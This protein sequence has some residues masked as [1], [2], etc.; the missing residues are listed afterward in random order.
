MKLERGTR[1]RNTES[2]RGDGRRAFWS[3]GVVGHAYGNVA[4]SSSMD[5]LTKPSKQRFRD[6]FSHR[7]AV[8]YIVRGQREPGDD[9]NVP[10]GLDVHS[11]DG[12]HALRRRAR[13]PNRPAPLTPITKVVLD[14]LA[15]S[16]H[17]VGAKPDAGRRRYRTC[18]CRDALW[19]PR[20]ICSA[21]NRGACGEQLAARFFLRPTACA[22]R[23]L[24]A[25]GRGRL[26]LYFGPF[27]NH[28]AACS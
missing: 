23:G 6:S 2:A 14:A 19:L 28:L 27:G 20:P 12:Q 10:K 25:S 22:A 9:L 21:A 11:A 7:V 26:R 4:R 17:N 1:S 3:G 18:Q 24:D 13:R 8:P 5:Q 16:S 15:F